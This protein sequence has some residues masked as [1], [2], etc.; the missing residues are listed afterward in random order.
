MAPVPCPSCQKPMNAQAVVCPHCNARRRDLPAGS[1]GKNL[2][3]AEIRAMLALQ[4][5]PP[6][7][8]ALSALLLPHPQTAGAARTAELVLTIISLPLV[9]SG[10]LALQLSRANRDRLQKVGGS[11][12]APVILMILVGS[13]VLWTVLDLVLHASGIAIAATLLIT[14]AALIARAVIRARAAGDD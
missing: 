13:G 4:A 1:V 5:G 14:T 8:G 10:A 7:R 12:T 6:Q 11:E 2:S 9:L 3:P